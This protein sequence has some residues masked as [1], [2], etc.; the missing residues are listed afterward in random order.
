MLLRKYANIFSKPEISSVLT[1]YTHCIAFWSIGLNCQMASIHNLTM[2]VHPSTLP[3]IT[4]IGTD[5]H[6][7]LAIKREC[8]P[9]G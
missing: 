3:A 8:G 1:D 6:P 5:V 2:H 7:Y 4:I 9:Q